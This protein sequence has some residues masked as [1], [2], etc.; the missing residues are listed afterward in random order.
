MNRLNYYSNIL[1]YV[2]LLVLIWGLNVFWRWLCIYGNDL[3]INEK[4]GIIIMYEKVC[5]NS[6][7]IK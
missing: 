1:C 4:L 2:E 3:F 6:E 5:W 7:Y